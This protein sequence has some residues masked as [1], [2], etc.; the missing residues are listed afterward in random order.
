MRVEVQAADGLTLVGDLY[1][2]ELS[3]QTP[4]VLLMHMYGG[5]R[6]DWQPLIPTL[7]GAGYRVVSVDLRGHGETGGSND[8]Q[9][10]IGDVQTWLDW[11][12][13]QPSIQPD[14]IAIVGASIG[15]NLALVGCANDTHCLTAVALSPGLDYFGITTSDAIQALRDRSALLVASQTDQPSGSSV[16]T[17]TTLAEGEFGLRL[18]PGS[19]HGTR[20]L[21][22]QSDSLIPLIGSWLDLHLR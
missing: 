8:W 21:T 20:L 13:A 22:T 3:V 18:Y 2:A 19:T 6:T 14:R 10:A 17:L 5:R 12:E 15:A 11:L 1:N 16:K 7:T 9:L 4:A